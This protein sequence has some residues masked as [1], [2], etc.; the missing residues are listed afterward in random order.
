V[1]FD[2]ELLEPLT[3]QVFRDCINETFSEIN[4]KLHEIGFPMLT[5][6][7]SEKGAFNRNQPFPSS[8]FFT[9]ARDEL[10]YVIDDEVQFY[11]EQYRRVHAI[12]Q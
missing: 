5:A 10:G 11:V 3:Q 7:V 2:S 4:K 8:G 9:C 6:I 1:R 12:W